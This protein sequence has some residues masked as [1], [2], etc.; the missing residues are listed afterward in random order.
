MPVNAAAY[1]IRRTTDSLQPFPGSDAVAGGSDLQ[2]AS[3]FLPPPIFPPSPIFLL[4][5]IL[6]SIFLLFLSFSSQHL[7]DCAAWKGFFEGLALRRG[8]GR[9]PEAS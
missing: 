4:S 5:I 2:K 1:I 7:K 8:P 3:L 6:L 9:S